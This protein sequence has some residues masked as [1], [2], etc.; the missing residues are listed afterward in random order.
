MELTTAPYILRSIYKDDEV[1]ESQ[2]ADPASSLLTNAVGARFTNRYDDTIRH[3]SRSVYLLATL[4][5]DQTLGNELCD[6]LPVCKAMPWAPIGVVRKV[7]LAGC[8]GLEEPVV[9]WVSRRLLP[10]YPAEDVAVTIKRVVLC[11][12]MLFER[13]G[14]I[15]HRLLRIRF[16]SLLPPGALAAGYGA[17]KTYLLP[18]LLIATGLLVQL[19]RLV[20]HRISAPRGVASSGVTAA[21][22]GE[23]ED[24]D[25]EADEEELCN[26]CFTKNKNPS[27]TPCG[28]VFCWACIAECAQKDA[29]CPLCRQSISLSS[30]VPLFFYKPKPPQRLGTE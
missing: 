18:G 26:V 5:N 28:H 22:S 17:P 12:L 6:L 19:Y 3:V 1:V 24:K 30:I 27:C 16:L 15:P 7:L 2:L 8:C 9:H 21:I 11:L 29:R 13:F 4:V 25:E 20:R 10:N 23:D 14:T